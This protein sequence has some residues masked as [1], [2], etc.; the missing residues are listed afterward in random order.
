MKMPKNIKDEVFFQ[1]LLSEIDEYFHL[2][3][4]AGCYPGFSDWHVPALLLLLL[5][6]VDPTSEEFL[7]SPDSYTLSPRMW[8]ETDGLPGKIF[9]KLDGFKLSPMQF[10]LYLKLQ[11]ERV[12]QKLGAREILEWS[13]FL[14]G[15]QD[16]FRRFI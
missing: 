1:R 10:E 13:N 15:N 6:G 7:S 11:T 16:R 8:R 2:M 12:S 9:K 14:A 5:V 4:G 3:G